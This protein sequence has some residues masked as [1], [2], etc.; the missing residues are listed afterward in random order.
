M[1]CNLS[2]HVLNN[3]LCWKCARKSVTLFPAILATAGAGI[4]DSAPEV[5][6]RSVALE[7]VVDTDADVEEVLLLPLLENALS[8]DLRNLLRDKQVGPKQIAKALLEQILRVRAM[9]FSL[10]STLELKR[11]TSDFVFSTLPD[12]AGHLYTAYFPH[13]LRGLRRTPPGYV[14]EALVSEQREITDM[15]HSTLTDLEQMGLAGL[16]VVDVT[17]SGFSES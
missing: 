12:D 6:T 4:A 17:S 10:A 14:L 9:Q 3:E 13:I 16:I 1:T 15:N 11:I 7:D 8:G 5:Y 2:P